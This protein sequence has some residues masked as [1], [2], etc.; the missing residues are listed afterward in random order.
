M[1]ETARQYYT[2]MASQNGGEAIPFVL[3]GERFQLGNPTKRISVR[4]P[5]SADVTY[6]Y[7]RVLE[8]VGS[9]ASDPSAP[10][11]EL[12]QLSQEMTKEH[13]PYYWVKTDGPF[14]RTDP[15]VDSLLSQNRLIP[16]K[17]G[18]SGAKL[19]TGYI[20][21]VCIEAVTPEDVPTK[22]FARATAANKQVRENTGNVLLVESATLV[23]GRAL[24]RVANLTVVAPDPEH[25][26]GYRLMGTPFGKNELLAASGMWQSV[27]IA[28]LL[29]HR[30][31]QAPEVQNT[32]RGK[33][34]HGQ[35][36]NRQ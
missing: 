7:T 27:A 21:D 29:E 24:G 3:S 1:S 4:S 12:G 9:F 13:G 30:G 33:R 25:F 35:G 2:E 11:V 34:A 22:L 14:E 20:K 5:Y 31:L 18:P 36:G 28:T 6:D 26:N 15:Y 10:L 23:L 16:K 19:V 17:Y 32:G 8:T